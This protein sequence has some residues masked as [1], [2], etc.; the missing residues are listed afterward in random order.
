[1]QK[2]IPKLVARY[3]STLEGQ[4]E[5]QTLTSEDL[6]DFKQSIIKEMNKNYPLEGLD[7]RQ[8]ITMEDLEEFKQDIFSE[9]NR[10]SDQSKKA[11]NQT[12]TKKIL[13]NLSRRSSTRLKKS[14]G[15]LKAQPVYR[16][17]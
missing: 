7:R 1:M 13:V 5:M 4:A 3:L 10:N 6:E 15:W 2:L 8:T 14:D 9:I 17:S 12:V 11:K 16:Y